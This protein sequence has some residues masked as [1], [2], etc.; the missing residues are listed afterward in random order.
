MTSRTRTTILGLTAGAAIT[1]TACGGG[2]DSARDE[3]IDRVVE[4]GVNRQAA[5]CVVDA[6]VAEWG[7]EVLD[8]AYEV[9]P[10]EIGR[11][12]EILDECL[13]GG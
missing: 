2:G 5:E 7:E 8:P 10:E 11:S 6:S 3:A 9:P 13:F 1:I 12:V 4:G